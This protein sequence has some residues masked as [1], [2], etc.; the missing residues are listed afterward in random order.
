MAWLSPS[1]TRRRRWV[2]PDAQDLTFLVGL[3]L[4]SVG[5][6]LVHLGAGLITP[7]AILI[8][9]ATRRTV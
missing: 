1:T 8:W 5:A 9:Q 2:A 3:L 6:A 7:G 4:V